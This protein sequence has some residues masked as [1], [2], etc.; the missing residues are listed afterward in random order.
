MA[1]L[2]S[3]GAL[4]VEPDAAPTGASK[5]NVYRL[6]WP[7]PPVIADAPSPSSL[8]PSLRQTCRP[9][10]V[11]GDALPPS[12][13][14]PITEEDSTKEDPTE[15]RSTESVEENSI[16]RG[17]LASLATPPKEMNPPADRDTHNPPVE[18]QLEPA[19]E[20]PGR[21]PAAPALAAEDLA[22]L[23]GELAGLARD[24]FGYRPTVEHDLEARLLASIEN[25]EPA[26]ASIALPTN[27]IPFRPMPSAAPPEPQELASA[28]PATSDTPITQTAPTPHTIA[29][30]A[31]TLDIATEPA[32][33]MT[34]FD[35]AQLMR[36]HAS[37]QVRFAGGGYRP[38]LLSLPPAQGHNAMHDADLAA[39]R[40][41]LARLGASLPLHDGVF[42]QLLSGAQDLIRAHH[43][44]M[45]APKSKRNAAAILPELPADP[46]SEE[47]RLL[48]L[49][50]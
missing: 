2:V 30:S 11:S 20:P 17:A 8:T 46:L 16:F 19:Q 48:Q 21:S 27:V 13:V 32:E 47:E 3:A 1:F 40:A 33:V 37:E 25:L 42:R 12:A 6:T 31:V 35:L 4:I 9:L 23:N 43:I 24:E 34:A 26:A 14:T 45:R 50:A 15:V 7:T 36:R 38:L 44:A 22:T 28:M 41:T 49:V 39:V 18:A 10:P 29:V 5:S